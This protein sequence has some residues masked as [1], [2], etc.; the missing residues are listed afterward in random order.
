MERGKI[1]IFDDT[2][3][4]LETLRNLNRDLNTGLDLVEFTSV[5]DYR[6][7]IEKLIPNVRVFI[8]DL[9]G[10]E[11]EVQSQKFEILQDIKTSYEK[12][13]VPIFIHSAHLA[14][15]DEFAEE[16]TVFKIEKGIDSARIIFDKIKLLSDSGFLDIFPLNGI[17]ETK[18][19]NDLH[20]AFIKQFKKNEI[21]GIIKSVNP[22]PPEHYKKRISSVFERIAFR[23]L[24]QELINPQQEGEE[25]EL[26]V[27]EHYYRRISKYGVWT[28]DIFKDK[29]NNN[30]FYVI[31]PRCNVVKDI[32]TR[33]L[34]C[35]VVN[36]LPK[37]KE[38]RRDAARNNPEF[39]KYKYRYL[40]KF[41]V[42]SGGKVN[43]S[44]I[45]IID[46]TALL[47]KEKYEYQITVSDELANEIA[48]M[49]GAYFLRTGITEFDL[50]ELERSHTQ[51]S[52]D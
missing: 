7:G 45:E 47:D 49:F 21:E 28:G 41:P 5:E 8:F 9:A 16:G 15:Y 39:S 31:T 52:P 32:T 35:E 26:N 51:E 4:I 24:L 22:L 37:K 3:Q 11:K 12:Y 34:V 23:S 50:E 25:I 40:P 13:R 30:L 27:A 48:G 19:M 20:R 1:I 42:F 14:H 2:V 38:T 36:E 29:L 46:R 6:K 44:T 10:N 18:I 43:V 17:I 33:I